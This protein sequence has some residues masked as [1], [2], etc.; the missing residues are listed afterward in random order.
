MNLSL[1]N[2]R[3]LYRRRANEYNTE[4]AQQ[5]ARRASQPAAAAAA[6]VAAPAGTSC[7]GRCAVSL[8]LLLLL[9]FRF[10]SPNVSF[11]L[12]S[13]CSAPAESNQ[14]AEDE[15]ADD[16]DYTAADA[17]A[18]EKEELQEE[19]SG[20]EEEAAAAAVSDDDIPIAQ[21]VK[22]VAK[23]SVTRAT[24]SLSL[25]VLAYEYMDEYGFVSV[26]AD[27]LLLSGACLND[28]DCSIDTTGWFVSVESRIA[29][30]LL[31]FGRVSLED[32]ER[33]KQSASTK[34]AALTQAATEFKKKC[35][36]NSDNRPVMTFK[37][38]LPIQ[39]K[40]EFAL[41]PFIGVY[42]HDYKEQ[43]D[44]DNF[45]RVLHLDFHGAV[46]P[47]KKKPKMKQSKKVLRSPLDKSLDESSSDSEEEQQQGGG[48]GRDANMG[49]ADRVQDG[50]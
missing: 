4:Q 29:E 13:C 49:G 47:T 17:A 11:V 3:N 2:F 37:F 40:P 14:D 19:V 46:Q 10:C 9:W 31:N 6:P 36:K 12:Y 38:K 27:V 8:L 23:M 25:P 50:W 26:T 24:C 39:C 7:A 30:A 15:D 20:L 1:K 28:L 44:M 43:S 35:K 33:N 5:G 16:A 42:K 32:H 41:K 45:Y 18:E 34:A 22:G 48:A 21:L